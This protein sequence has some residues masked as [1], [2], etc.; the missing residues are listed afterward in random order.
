MKKRL[1][2]L[3]V[4]VAALVLG[5][6]YFGGGADANTGTHMTAC[7]AL[8]QQGVTYIL[9][10]SPPTVNG[11]NADPFPICL[12]IT[13]DGITLL[14]N[15][16]TITGGTGSP[17]GVTLDSVSGVVVKNLTFDNLTEGIKKRHRFN[18]WRFLAWN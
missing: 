15:G 7:Q 10:Q 14:G 9:D 17:T 4:V 18:R 6:T 2:S 16:N 5:L 8:D 13:A 1:I 3:V 11:T 12:P